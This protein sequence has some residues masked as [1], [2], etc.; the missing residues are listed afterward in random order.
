[1]HIVHPNLPFAGKREQAET[2]F[3]GSGVEVAESRSG[4]LS[5][6]RVKPGEGSEGVVLRQ[7][8]QNYYENLNVLVLA[9]PAAGGSRDSIL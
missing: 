4:T 6:W 8:W 7:C 9:L 5:M 2:I 3:G 1:M